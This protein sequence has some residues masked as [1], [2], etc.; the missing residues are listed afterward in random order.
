MAPFLDER[1]RRLFTASE[2]RAAGRGGVTAVATAT[3][4]ARSTIGRGLAEVRLGRDDLGSRIRRPGGGRK[5]AVETQ[6]GLLEALSELV[7]SAIRGDPEAALLWVSKSQRHLARA[8]TERGF[9]AGPTLVGRLLRRLGFSLQ[10]NRK[11]REGT[12]HPDRD[13]QFE[14]INA[15]VKAWQTAGQPAISV[16][17]KKKEPV[18]DFKNGGRELRPKGQ[19]EAVRVHDFEDKGLG[20]VVPYGVSDTAANKGWVRLG[21]DN[22]TAAFAVETIRRWWE[23]IGR[24]RHPG[25][26]RL[27]VTADSGGPKHPPH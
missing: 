10:A 7:Q 4:V 21:V 26:G 9:A 12:S 6:P 11:T 5:P 3:R 1:G 27:L 13:A 15:R 8:L 23:T 25:A 20:K 2:A 22:D 24:A 17:T 14:S 19:P 18:G 16:D